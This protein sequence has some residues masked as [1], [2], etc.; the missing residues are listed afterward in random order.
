M[1]KIKKLINK[2]KKLIKS[3]Y[4]KEWQKYK[5]K[6]LKLLFMVKNLNLIPLLTSFD[7][8]LAYYLNSHNS[9]NNQNRMW[10][11]VLNYLKIAPIIFFPIFRILKSKNRK[12][13]K[14]RRKR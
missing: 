7:L 12:L 10:I 1:I 2:N 6:S 5:V 8:F 4:A 3:I 14:K 11:F 9:Q 13:F